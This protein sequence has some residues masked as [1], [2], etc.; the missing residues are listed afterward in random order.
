MVMLR[1][2]DEGESDWQPDLHAPSGLPL[3]FNGFTQFC[4]APDFAVAPQITVDS[5]FAPFQGEK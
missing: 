4:G 3:T 1:R 5:E 2:V